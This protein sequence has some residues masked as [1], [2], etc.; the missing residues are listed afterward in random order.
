VLKTLKT[1][2]FL[3]SCI[4]LVFSLVVA[5][6]YVKQEHPVYIWD[7][8]LLEG[9]RTNDYNPLPAVLL[10]P[11][12]CLFGGARPA[13]ISALILLYLY[14]VGLLTLC[15][16]RRLIT[17][18]LRDKPMPLGPVFFT[19]AF[20]FIPFWG[21]TL[22]GLPD[23]VG[24]VPIIL[25]ILLILSVDFSR[26][27]VYRKAVI[28]GILLWAP[29]LLRRWYAYTIVSLYLTLPWFN[30]FLHQSRQDP[31]NHLVT[32]RN[33]TTNFFI[34]GITSVAG[35]LIFQGTLIKRILGTDYSYIYSAYQGSFGYSLRG[36]YLDNGLLVMLLAGLGFWFCLTHTKRTFIIAGF[37]S[38]NLVISFL[39]FTRTQ[40]PGIHH[41]IPFSFWI[42]LFYLFGLYDIS[43]FLKKKGHN[44]FF[45]FLFSISIAIVFLISLFGVSSS[46]PG[47]FLFPVN[48]HPLRINHI[49]NYYK[50]VSVLEQLTDTGDKLS[51]ISSN[52]NLSDDL[53]STIS[54]R[55]MDDRLVNSSQVDL[56]DK[57]L[58][59]PFTSR[60]LLLADPVQLHLEPEG[61]RVVTI[62]AEI[63][64]EGRLIGQAYRKL[65][66]DFLL[67]DD[68]HA[69]I[70]E[71][72]RPFTREEVAAFLQLFYK[73]YPEWQTEYENSLEVSLLS[74][75]ISL[76]DV[77]GRF[78]RSGKNAIFAHPGQ[79]RPTIAKLYYPY[80]TMLVVSLCQNSQPG[81]G[82]V[83]TIEQ[84]GKKTLTRRVGKGES[85]KLDVTR[86]G[87]GEIRITIDKNKSPAFDSVIIKPY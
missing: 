31:L 44:F 52:G 64:L 50:M 53:V 7:K 82:V 56:K 33:L 66:Y 4:F 54:D 55:K 26:K 60:Y 14:P 74:A 37:I 83:I 87:R 2:H 61:Q 24:M 19:A 22:R 6:I 30:Y 67:N 18:D 21:P 25:A 34:A 1:K 86:F 40:T 38:T 47:N 49:D 84:E 41:L 70:F 65:N 35:A 12:Y 42:L 75:S 80:D 17:G 11:F 9:I 85:L 10:F 32:L 48:Y 29:F 77:W 13:Y 78:D 79:N 45:E 62:P 27:P 73:F 46:F 15:L 8:A 68:I 72:T 69:Y 57:I 3:Y 58:L 5:L 76:G 39:H 71:K 43:S 63:I 51:V 16:F 28:L 23:I 81:D 20:L 36:L 59:Q